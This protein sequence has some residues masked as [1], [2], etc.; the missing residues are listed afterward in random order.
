M[1]V[2]GCKTWK[3]HNMSSLCIETVEREQLE[4]ACLCVC[5]FLCDAAWQREHALLGRLNLQPFCVCQRQHLL[6]QNMNWKTSVLHFVI[7]TLSLI[8]QGWGGQ[9][10]ITFTLI[11]VIYFSL[12]W[13][14]YCTLHPLKLQFMS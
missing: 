9:Y 6:N 10:K 4:W 3:I 13:G 14:K 7:V 5:A 11:T 12:F 1:L 8:I 2:L